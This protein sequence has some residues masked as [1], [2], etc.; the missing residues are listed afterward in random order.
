VTA[1]K[2]SW[3]VSARPTSTGMTV[4]PVSFG[5]SVVTTS[6]AAVASART[7]A[8]VVSFETDMPATPDSESSTMSAPEFAVLPVTFLDVPKIG[9]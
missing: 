8:A 1:G 2:F 6:S 7:S 4:V 3:V 5:S 9:S